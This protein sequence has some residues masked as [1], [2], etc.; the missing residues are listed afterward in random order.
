MTATRLVTVI[1][2]AEAALLDFVV[3]AGVE[4]VMTKLTALALWVDDVNEAD[5]LAMFASLPI[6][7]IPCEP[8][9]GRLND[10]LALNTI[11]TMKQQ[12]D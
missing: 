10:L 8:V 11:F 12:L 2:G 3:N 6:F 4:V 7:A 5:I 9:S 1:V